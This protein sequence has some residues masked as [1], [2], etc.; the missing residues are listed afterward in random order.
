MR[1][2]SV[3]ELVTRIAQLGDDF[4]KAFTKSS[5]LSGL[6]SRATNPTSGFVWVTTSAKNSYREHSASSHTVSSPRSIDFSASR[7]A[8]LGSTTAIRKTLG[9]VEDSAAVDQVPGNG[10]D[11]SERYESGR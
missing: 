2:P 11:A 7:E 9:I 6:E 4:A 8:S 10:C 3:D 5:A 1:L